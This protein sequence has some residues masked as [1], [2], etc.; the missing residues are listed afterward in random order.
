MWGKNSVADGLV[1]MT[2]DDIFDTYQLY[3]NHLTLLWGCF[4]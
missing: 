1:Y 3:M 4:S 2:T